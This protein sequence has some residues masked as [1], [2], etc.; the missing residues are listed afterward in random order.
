LKQ[1]GVQTLYIAPGS[2]WENGYIESFNGRLRDE[3][4]NV[5]I[6]DTMLEAKIL[7][8]RWRQIYN[9]IRPHSS[10]GYRPP[11]P[12]TWLVDS[13]SRDPSRVDSEIVP[14]LT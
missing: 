5:E 13:L 8:E 7:I 3:L 2:P 11:A 10:L 1:V 4:L 6:F 12:E 9:K 14:G